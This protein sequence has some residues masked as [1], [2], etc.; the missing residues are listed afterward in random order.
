MA[1]NMEERQYPPFGKCLALSN[2]SAELLVSLDFGPR[3]LSYRLADGENILQPDTEGKLV[4][5]DPKLEEYYGDGTVW[6]NYGGHRLWVSPEA[7]PQTYYP[8]NEPVSYEILEDKV[9]FT[10]PAQKKNNWQYVITV[11]MA[12][13]SSNVEIRH[14]I[15]NLGE[16]RKAGVWSISVMSRNGFEVIPQPDRPTGLL[17]N[18]VFAV[19]PYSNMS[20]PRICWG[21]EFITLQQDTA[22]DGPFKIGL[23]NEHGWAAYF[24]KGCC[25]VKRFE[26]QPEAAYPDGGM[27]FE[28]YTCPDFIEIESLSPFY[29]L[30]SGEW[31]EHTEHWEL[32]KAE[33]CNPKDQNAVA[34]LVQKMGLQ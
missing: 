29:T 26:H 23:N 10:P 24:N 21:K 8:D 13:D 6:N 1:V 34:G 17:A 3:I 11:S 5:K 20:D 14:R 12:E 22:S 2:G 32:K 4:T 25:F 19:W 7:M 27:S 33:T 28:T 31:M 16:T 18:R 15:I 30:K 9:I